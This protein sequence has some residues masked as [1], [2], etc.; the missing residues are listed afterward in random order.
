MAKRRKVIRAGRIVY[1]TIS[2]MA[3]PSDPDHVRSAKEKCSTAARQRLNMKKS[4]QKL[5]LLLSTNFDRH[6]LHVVLT[7]RDA[8][9][10][11]GRAAALIKLRK[12]LRQLRDARR[13]QGLPL[14]YVY[15]TEGLH[16]DK[17]LHHHLVINGTGRDLELLRSLWIWGDDIHLEALDTYAGYEA[18]AKYLTKEPRDAGAP[19]GKRCWTPSLNLKRPEV[20]ASWVPDDVTLCAPPGAVV[21]DSDSIRNEYGEFTYIKYMLPDKPHKKK[22][23]PRTKRAAST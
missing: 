18:L 4:W 22:S 14:R 12:F 15:I 5:E 10:P 11:P 19:N 7:Y 23:R 8:D 6:D 20:D 3:H 9:L 17:R 21:L 13:R 16:G 2:S 1:A